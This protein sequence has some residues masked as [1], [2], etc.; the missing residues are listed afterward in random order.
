MIERLF[1]GVVIICLS[2]FSDMGLSDFSLTVGVKLPSTYTVTRWEGEPV[3]A[4]DGGDGIED[5]VFVFLFLFFRI[6]ALT[7][8]I[9]I[10]AAMANMARAAAPTDASE[11][12]SPVLVP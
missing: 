8:S 4:V 5:S 11:P 2:P 1:L 7:K 6:R 3:P 12:A 9:A 10:N